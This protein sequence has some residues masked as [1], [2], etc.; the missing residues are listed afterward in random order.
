MFCY[1]VQDIVLVRMLS[2]CTWNLSCERIAWHLVM[3]EG[4][5]L[6][7]CLVLLGPLLNKFL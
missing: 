3:M 5:G 7:L 2:M 4:L 1:S 6:K